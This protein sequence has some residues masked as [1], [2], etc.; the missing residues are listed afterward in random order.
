MLF[1][2]PLH[3]EVAKAKFNFIEEKIWVYDV[4]EKMATKLAIKWHENPLKS[5]SPSQYHYS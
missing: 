4:E 3:R 1:W 5:H 2:F